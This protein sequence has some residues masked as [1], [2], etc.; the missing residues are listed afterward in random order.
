[1]TSTNVI[2]IFGSRADALGARA[3]LVDAG[4]DPE[5]LTVSPDL[6]ADPMAAEAPGQAYA[7]QRTTTG[8][9][10]GAWIKSGFRS[11]L[12]SDTADAERMADIQRG[13]AVLTIASGDADLQRIRTLIEPHRPVAVRRD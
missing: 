7:N 6:T 11:G 9:G 4:F 13:G 1:M 8:A 2:A 12:D 10:V 3:A 5:T